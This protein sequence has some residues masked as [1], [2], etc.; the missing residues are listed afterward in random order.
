M[1]RIESNHSNLIS[2]SDAPYDKW[3]RC[4]NSVAII[5]VRIDNEPYVVRFG[6]FTNAPQVFPAD[7]YIAYY[8]DNEDSLSYE[9]VDADINI[10]F[11]RKESQ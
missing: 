5:K 6:D 8:N 2:L 11:K 3:L 9:V 1:I 7:G 4:G 10:V